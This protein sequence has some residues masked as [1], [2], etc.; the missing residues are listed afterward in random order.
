MTPP[1]GASGSI[2]TTEGWSDVWR[3]PTL[4]RSF[5]S[6]LYF[7]NLCF[8]FLNF[9]LYL[10]LLFFSSFLLL[11]R[12]LLLLLRDRL[13]SLRDFHDLDLR[14]LPRPS[15]L[16]LRLLFFLPVCHFLPP[17]LLL[18]Y[19]LSPVMDPPLLPQDFILHLLLLLNLQPDLDLV[20]DPLLVL[21]S[22]LLPN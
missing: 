1:G 9:F 7:L 13:P 16:L 17:L 12:L 8:S 20:P 3:V 5:T 6:R 19:F 2:V 4:S 15:P 10:S 11:L 22:V 21:E 14:L 18:L